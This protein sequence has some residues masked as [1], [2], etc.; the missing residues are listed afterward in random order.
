MESVGV[1][2][3]VPLWSTGPMP[4]MVTSVAPVVCQVSV[5]GW[6]GSTVL[7]FAE[8]EAVGAKA[9]GGGGGGGGAAFLAHAPRNISVP[10]AITNAAYLAEFGSVGVTNFLLLVVIA[11][12]T[13][14]SNLIV[15][16]HCGGDLQVDGRA[17]SRPAAIQFPTSGNETL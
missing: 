2:W 12:F 3:R 16:P 15:R 7:G 5:V 9:S 14:S 17:H 1:T 6:P 10:S 11:R 8:S 4:S 13:Y